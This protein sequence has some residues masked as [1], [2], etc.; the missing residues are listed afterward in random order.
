M[1]KK[2]NTVAIITL[3]ALVVVGVIVVLV[4]SLGKKKDN[5]TEASPTPTGGAVQ[6]ADAKTDTDS[7]ENPA[8]T[9]V[10]TDVDEENFVFEEGMNDIA[11][12]KNGY[13]YSEDIILKVFSRKGGTIYYTLDGSDPIENGTAY[14]AAKGISMQSTP[15]TQPKIYPL[16]VAAVYDDGTN[17]GVYV[18]TYFVGA[19]VSS[20]YTTYIF[21]I[22]GDPDELD[23][24]PDG[25][26]YGENYEERG[27]E[28]ERGIHLEVLASDG[29]PVLSQFAGIRVYGAYSRQYWQ[30]SMK[31]FARSSYD[32]NYSSFRLSFVDQLRQDGSGT[33][34]LNYDKFVLRDSG[35]D[36]Q[37]AYVR[38][39]LNQVLAAKAGYSDYEAVLPAIAYRNGKYVGFFWLHA[40]YCNDYFLDKYGDNPSLSEDA[41]TS[42]EFI[43]LEGGDK[44]KNSDSDELVSKMADEYEDKYEDF[45]DRDVSNDDVYKELCQ[46]M[47]VESYLDFF[48]IN[49]YLNNKDWPNNNYKCYAYVP[50]KGESYTEGTVFDGRW[51]YLV[52][53][54]DY[55]L[56]LYDQQETQATYDTLKIVMKSSGDRNS[57]LFTELMAR[58]DC[59]EY[60]VKKMLDLANGAFSYEYLTS[61]LKAINDDRADEMVYYYNFLES[62][63]DWG[64]WTQS[65]HF[66]GF[67]QV[68]YSFA[69]DRPARSASYLKSA[70]SLGNQ[71]KLNITN[72]GEAKLVINSWT[73]DAGVNF[74]GSY[75]EDYETTVRAM[76]PIGYEIDY[77]EV[78]GAKKTGKNLTITASD[79]EGTEVNVVLHLKASTDDPIVLYDISARDGDYIVL[80]NCTA[81]EA[82]LSGYSLTIG[83]YT[84]DL[85]S[86]KLAA[87]GTLTIYSS[88]YSGE[89]EANA[90][91]FEANLSA[92][93]VIT[94]KN[95]ST[96]VN[97]L[98]LPKTHSGFVMRFD[99]YTREFTEVSK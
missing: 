17:S 80:R 14:D 76:A 54:M 44:F 72:D 3:V 18:H 88:N 29:T 47:D 91:V 24:G 55:T 73:T 6:T 58:D 33:Q 19:K 38:D 10:L 51:R 28:S 25:I 8:I 37:F 35:N 77:W 78:N 64:V 87:N 69:K 13:F 45:V 67:T 74:T 27:M 5:N 32:S 61:T 52:H 90:P 57:P 62:S 66:Q 56:G 39:E 11:F 97:S 68:I 70:F 2:K 1:N 48:A 63:H 16:S 98:T 60:F 53:D 89:K 59:R 71:Y 50:A 21:N 20:R 40:S 99:V 36:Y 84:Y 22:V 86:S 7:E 34:I 9:P 75:F 85:P 82:S 93:D 42:G 95:G 65:E 4:T 49:I 12:T 15:G 23:N 46:W 41:E 96:T 26:F 31:L 30:K 94:L 81:S 83:D 79:I 92:D 43:V